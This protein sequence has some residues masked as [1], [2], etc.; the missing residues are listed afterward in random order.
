MSIYNNSLLCIEYMKHN[1]IVFSDFSYETIFNT[2]ITYIENMFKS[3]HINLKFYNKTVSNS[4]YDIL[5]K[6]PEELD[7]NTI[8]TMYC[9]FENM[10]NYKLRFL[11]D[12]G[13]Y[14]N[15]IIDTT[16]SLTLQIIKPIQVS[17]D[18]LEF[19]L[20]ETTFNVIKTIDNDMITFEPELSNREIFDKILRYFTYILYQNGVKIIIGDKNFCGRNI[21]VDAKLHNYYIDED[22]FRISF[23]LLAEYLR[24]VINRQFNNKYV[25]IYVND[26]TFFITFRY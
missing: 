4:Y 15:I 23:C 18:N 12:Q 22:V 19:T 7:Q 26:S 1:D 10:F 17:E 8:R 24:L 13:I 9:L 5:I 20:L 3:L 11:K 25:H 21:E 14:V 6:Y 2:T 16:F